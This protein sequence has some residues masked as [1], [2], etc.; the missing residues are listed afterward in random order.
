MKFKCPEKLR[1]FQLSD[2]WNV[3]RRWNWPLKTPRWSK[4]FVPALYWVSL[5]FFLPSPLLRRS[6]SS[7]PRS[8][9]PLTFAPYQVSCDATRGG[10]RRSARVS[11]TQPFH[12]PHPHLPGVEEREPFRLKPAGHI[13]L[14]TGSYKELKKES[15]W[16]S[17]AH[18]WYINWWF[19]A[20]RHICN[21]NISTLVLLYPD[22][23]HRGTA[24]QVLLGFINAAWASCMVWACVSWSVLAI[25]CTDGGW[26]EM[27]S[28]GFPMESSHEV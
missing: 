14:F 25:W 8:P 6:R 3:S 4:R 16:A 19:M 12:F 13:C 20:Q 1:R 2:A 11:P 10:G 15:S 18:L 22:V 9:L 5:P 23:R 21:A 24:V 27:Q 7:D 26:I 28:L 17:P